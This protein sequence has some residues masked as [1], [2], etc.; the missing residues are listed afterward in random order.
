LLLAGRQA[1]LAPLYDIASALPYGIDER[2]LR[3]AMKVGGDY[4]LHPFH[5]TWPKAAREL[6]LDAEA[7]TGRV[8]E[9]ARRAPDAFADAAAAPAVA[10]LARPLPTAL[11]D[12]VAERSRRCMALLDDP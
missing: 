11:L 9:L 8:L 10:G 5:N 6:D 7:V 2:K 1:R 3:L 4:R 12:L